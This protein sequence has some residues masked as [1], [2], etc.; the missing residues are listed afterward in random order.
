LYGVE[1]ETVDV[2]VAQVHAGVV[3]EEVLDLSLPS[4]EAF[5]PGSVV[6]VDVVDAAGYSVITGAVAVVLPVTVVELAGVVVDDVKDYGEAQTVGR[7]DQLDEFGDC[8]VGCGGV[9]IF[10]REHV[11]GPVALAGSARGVGLEV[12][13]GQELDGI[14]AK[15][16]DVW[17]AILEVNEGRGGIWICDAIVAAGEGANVEL[18][19][20]EVFKGGRGKGVRFALKRPGSTI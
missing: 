17:Q 1:P 2:I 19:N 16:A 6:A 4:C 13:D 5:T 11:R 8:L 10:G 15:L 14:E 18:V 20:E 9:Q 12:R 3:E 7:I